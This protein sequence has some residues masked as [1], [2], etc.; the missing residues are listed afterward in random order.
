MSKY[1]YLSILFLVLIFSSTCNAVQKIVL[2][3]QT[4]V[5][6]INAWKSSTE[7]SYND[8]NNRAFSYNIKT[9]VYKPILKSSSER[10]NSSRI[11]A[12]LNDEGTILYVKKGNNVAKEIRLPEGQVCMSVDFSP[13]ERYLYLA[14]A[15]KFE[16]CY[17]YKILD[18]VSWK[19]ISMPYGQNEVSTGNLVW[20]ENEKYCAIDISQ[21]KTKNSEDY[22]AVSTGILIFDINNKKVFKKYVKEGEDYWCLKDYRNGEILYNDGKFYLNVYNIN[23]NS[24]KSLLKEPIEYCL[25]GPNR[26]VYAVV[27]GRL[28]KILFN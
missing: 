8:I 28:T 16:S 20:L 24:T 7:F 13:G 11:S 6:A 5:L 18:T 12:E 2:T 19:I 10:Q 22:N 15:S 21:I 26:E 17:I 23:S 3:N 27:A 9:G 25:W 4:D 1:M 14:I